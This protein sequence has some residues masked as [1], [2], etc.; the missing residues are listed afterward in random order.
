MPTTDII[1]ITDTLQYTPNAFAAP[2][3]ITE[4]YFRQSIG[5]I[6]SIIK[7]PPKKLPFL[8]YGDSTKNA[9]NQ[10][11]HIFQQIISQPHLPILPLPPM[12]PQIQNQI[13]LPA[14]I[15]HPDAQ[16]PRVEPVVQHPRVQPYMTSPISPPRVQHSP[17]PTLEPFKNPWI[18]KCIIGRII[19][20]VSQLS[21]IHIYH[22]NL[23]ITYVNPYAIV[24]TISA[25]NQPS[26]LWHT[27]CPTYHIISTYTIRRVI[28]KL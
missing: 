9:I 2:K 8:S 16:A 21:A 25:L 12:L 5:D 3:T 11:A 13:Q 4:D 28:K 6:L 26:T 24:V 22:A 18:E 1:C 20:Q 17:S 27:I 19:N 14:M 10:I 7:Y 23:S 15:I